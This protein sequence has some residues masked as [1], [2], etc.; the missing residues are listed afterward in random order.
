MTRNN[1]QAWYDL[2]D[3]TVA[4]F[5]LVTILFFLFKNKWIIMHRIFK[6]LICNNIH[7]HRHLVQKRAFLRGISHIWS[8]PIWFS[9]LS[10]WVTGCL[11]CM[12]FTFYLR[13]R[14]NDSKK[15]QCISRGNTFQS[16]NFTFVQSK[17]SRHNFVFLVFLFYLAKS[18]REDG[19]SKIS[20][21]LLSYAG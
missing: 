4:K 1:K 12:C 14:I 18:T 11:L 3:C 10:Y 20:I 13:G 5:L 19:L 15:S 6:K 9:Y 8:N 7:F 21:I 16:E 17:I 2:P